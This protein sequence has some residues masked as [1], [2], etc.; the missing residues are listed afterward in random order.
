MHTLSFINALAIELPDVGTAEALAFLLN[1]TTLL[2]VH[3]VLG[4]YDDLVVSV[5]PI[6][7]APPPLATDVR[8]G[9]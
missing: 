2:G 3:P 7:P 1:Y 9:T 5:L 8:L 6:T 4:V